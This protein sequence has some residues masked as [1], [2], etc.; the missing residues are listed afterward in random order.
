[1]RSDRLDDASRLNA[2]M[3]A[4]ARRRGS[5]IVR[6]AA[7]S[8]QALVNWRRGRIPDAAAD[9]SMAIDLG[10]NA[11]GADALLTA[12]RAVQALVALTRGA[13]ASELA[14]I[15]AEVLDRRPDPDALP[16][17]P[18]GIYARPRPHRAGRRRPRNRR[19]PGGGRVS[20]AWGFGNPTTVPW[21]SD[22][23]LA[24]ARAGERV[25]AQRLAAGGAGTAEE[26]R[27]EARDRPR[28]TGRCVL[29]AD[30]A[31]TLPA[32]ERAVVTLTDSPALLDP[33]GGYGGSRRRPAARRTKRASARR[34]R[35]TWRRSWR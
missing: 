16:Y 5:V 9:C 27:R 25:Q 34:K 15:E 4:E 29:V 10:E 23:A 35:A 1:M 26:L 12:A 18:G 19:P 22:A 33:R 32:L 3:L 20:V 8:M 24:L 21:R 2:R 28:P 7:G 31:T 30:D 17:H 11:H 14:A 6:C 13:D